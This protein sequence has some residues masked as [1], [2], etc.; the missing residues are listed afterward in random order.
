MPKVVVLIVAGDHV[1]VMPLLAV[2]GS[3][4]GVAF[5]Q[6]GP[7]KLNDGVTLGVTEI[8]IVTIVAH[9][10]AVGVNV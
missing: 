9:K 5:W 4:A 1:P 3:T 8:V 7:N 6:Y 2:E 10:P